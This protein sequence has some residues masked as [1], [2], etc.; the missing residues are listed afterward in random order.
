MPW[1][2][3]IHRNDYLE[4]K[5]PSDLWNVNICTTYDC[6]HK[7]NPPGLHPCAETKYLSGARGADSCRPADTDYTTNMQFS[8]QSQECLCINV[9]SSSNSIPT[10]I[11]GRSKVS[12]VL[13]ELNHYQNLSLGLPL[14]S[15]FGR[16]NGCSRRALKISGIS[17]VMFLPFNY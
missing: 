1:K 9:L 14:S 15:K 2:T 5:C 4:L 17:V 8:H 6:S 13:L 3:L 16:V 12:S 11:G 10:Q 7:L